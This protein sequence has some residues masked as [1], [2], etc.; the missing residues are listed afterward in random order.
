[1]RIGGKLDRLLAE[2]LRVAHERGTLRTK[3]MAGVTVETTVQ[4]KNVAFP[5]DGKLTHATIKGLN[6]L[7]R[8]T[9]LALPV[10]RLVLAEL[11]EQDHG[12]KVGPG[13]ATR[14][15]GG[16]GNSDR[17]ISGASA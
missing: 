1:M 13:K 6:R 10:E 5:T 11:L 8:R 9:A 12:Q 16:P 4:P 3:D 14:R 17:T 15:R 7:P 2:S